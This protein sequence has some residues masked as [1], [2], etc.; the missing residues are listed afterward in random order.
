MSNPNALDHAASVVCVRSVHFGEA[1][2]RIT[3]KKAAR[4]FRSWAGLGALASFVRGLCLPRLLKAATSLSRL[5]CSLQRSVLRKKVK[6][7]ESLVVGGLLVEGQVRRMDGQMDRQ[8]DRQTEKIRQPKQLKSLVVGG[9]LICLSAP[10]RAWHQ[11]GHVQLQVIALDWGFVGTVASDG[12]APGRR[13]E[14]SLRWRGCSR[15]RMKA[16]LSGFE[17]VCLSPRPF[18]WRPV[19]KAIGL[20]IALSPRPDEQSAR[21]VCLSV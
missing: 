12:T 11:D 8:T 21:L 18:V 17:S 7:L 5:F 1:A 3:T 6:L 10:G 4:F 19:P 9:L 2:N 13:G 16:A 15:T 14:G 20:S